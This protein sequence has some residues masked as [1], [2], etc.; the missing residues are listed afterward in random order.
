MRDCENPPRSIVLLA[1]KFSRF[2]GYNR[3]KGSVFFT[4]TTSYYT[5]TKSLKG[6]FL[7]YMQRETPQGYTVINEKR[8]WRG[9]W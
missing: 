3:H 8:G 7:K 9:V 1:A 6:K 5:M 4:H 2:A